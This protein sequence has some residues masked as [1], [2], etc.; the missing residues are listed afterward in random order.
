MQNLTYLVC[1]ILLCFSSCKTPEIDPPVVITPITPVV[2]DTTNITTPRLVWRVRILPDSMNSSS[3]TPIGIYK[4]DIFIFDS[5]TEN[6][7]DV[8]SVKM[9]DTKTGKIKWTWR[10]F[11]TMGGATAWYMHN[12]VAAFCDGSDIDVLNLDTG[13]KLWTLN[14]PGEGWNRL[15]GEGENLYYM[16]YYGPAPFEDEAKLIKTNIYNQNWETVFTNKK[17]GNLCAGLEL[18]TAVTNSKG[19]RILF[20][21]QRALYK[22]NIHGYVKLF[23]F[24]ETKKKLEWQTDSLDNNSNVDPPLFY[25]NRVYFNGDNAVFCFDAETGNQI[26]KWSP[27]KY[28]SLVL[29][30]MI[31][32]E[33][34][35]FVKPDDEAMYCLN[36]DNGKEIWKNLTNDG[37]VCDNPTYH[38]GNIY[39]SSWSRRDLYAVDAAT[40]K[41]FWTFDMPNWSGGAEIGIDHEKNLMY[42]SDRRFIYCFQIPK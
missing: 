32:G 23:A 39:Y 14:K 30:D 25:K 10:G 9:I 16:L 6:E 22:H 26:W 5:V 21:Q 4:N 15:S 17:E 41:V 1:S 36:L 37:G 40:G 24:N 7:K 42:A 2:I 31:I 34:K 38:K 33:D 8:A 3:F 18:P 13:T 27:E 35:L 12:N 28:R 20:F 29:G 11:R 19:E